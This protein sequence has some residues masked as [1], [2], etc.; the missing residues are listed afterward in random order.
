MGA[1]YSHEC[2][3][4]VDLWLGGGRG[5]GKMDGRKN[6]RRVDGKELDAKEM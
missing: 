5:E 4:S 6:L 3:D 1:D 2:S